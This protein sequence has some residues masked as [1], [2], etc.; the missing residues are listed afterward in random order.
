[1]SGISRPQMLN[2]KKGSPL[3][4]AVLTGLFVL[5]VAVLFL[6]VW[7]K[8]TCIGISV[9]GDSMYATVEDGEFLYARK[10]NDAERGD[11]VII[12][13]SKYKQRDNLTGDYI[14]KRLIATEGDVVSCVDGVVYVQYRGTDEAVALQED[15]TV[16]KTGDFSERT[17]GEGEIYFLGDH[18]TV[19]YDSRKLGK[20]QKEDIIGVVPEWAIQCKE[21]TTGLER[22]RSKI[23]GLFN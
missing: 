11:V 10:G 18:R 19:S 9:V 4:S 7:I 22:V 21:F 3:V 1:M 8:A 20:Y 2:E 16:G 14:I 13:V 12:D 5:L 23:Y 17:V 6:D 15:Y